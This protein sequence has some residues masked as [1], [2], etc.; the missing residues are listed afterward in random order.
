MQQCHG[1]TDLGTRVTLTDGWAASHLFLPERVPW[2]SGHRWVL[3]KSQAYV[4]KKKN[5]K[6]LCSTVNRMRNLIKK[7]ED[8]GI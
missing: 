3:A 5:N 4:K 8:S 7:T 1:Q 2:G 6:N